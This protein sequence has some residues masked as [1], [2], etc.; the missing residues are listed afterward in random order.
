MNNFVIFQNSIERRTIQE[1]SKQEEMNRQFPKQSWTS[2][3]LKGKLLHGVA[4]IL[5]NKLAKLQSHCHT[6]FNSEL[7]LLSYLSFVLSHG[8]HFT[9]MGFFGKE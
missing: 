2:E 1:K 6:G 9:F 3:E 8:K 7:S 4:D 5:K